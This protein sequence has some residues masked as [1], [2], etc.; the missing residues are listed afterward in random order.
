LLKQYRLQSFLE[1]H[2]RVLLFGSERLSD[3]DVLLLTI[4]SPSFNFYFFL[5]F[6]LL[7]PFL[8]L[9]CLLRPRISKSIFFDFFVSLGF[10]FLGVSF[11]GPF[12]LLF[13]SSTNSKSISYCSTSTFISLT[14][15]VSPILKTWP[16][17]FPIRSEEH[18]SELQS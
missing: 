8:D 3:F 6:L 5:R 12:F 13:V 16:V 2:N 7:F 10:F 11:F 17:L 1:C 18:T 14:L 15:T 9:F 4:H